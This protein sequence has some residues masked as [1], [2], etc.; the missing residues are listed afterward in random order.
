MDV[1]FRNVSLGDESIQV[2]SEEEE[3]EF[4]QL[5][6]DAYILPSTGHRIFVVQPGMVMYIIKRAIDMLKYNF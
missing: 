3:E 1:N 4:Q 6:D 2:I 5:I